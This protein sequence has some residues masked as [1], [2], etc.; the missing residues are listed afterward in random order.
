M[1]HLLLLTPLI[2]A[3]QAASMFILVPLYLYPGRSASAWSNVTAAIKAYPQ[4]QWQVIIN[5]G[6]GPN[7]TTC[8]TDTDYIYAI[9]SMN[10]HANVM[11]LGYVDTAFANRAYSL[12]VQDINTYASWW[13]CNEQGY[14]VSIDGI[15]FDDVNN[16]ASSSVFTYMQNAANYAYSQVPSD[17]TPVVFNPGALA[18]TQL[19]S[20]C[21]TMIQF[22]NVYSLYNNATTIKTIPSAYR[23]QSAILV[24]NTLETTAPIGSLVHT[25]AYYGIEA[26]Y[27]TP[28]ENPSAYHTFDLDLLEQ[29][30]AAVAAG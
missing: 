17:V 20:Y 9:S 14:N 10:S 18:P 23:G 2:L 15:F 12:V 30:A 25:M 16:T 19:F 5:P 26:V 6:D 1:H 27:F 21:S 3:L 7:I 24:T 13:N 22:E 29:I 11:T 8:P 28:D 4:V